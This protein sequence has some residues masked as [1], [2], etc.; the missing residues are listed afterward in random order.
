LRS[1][2]KTGEKSLQKT[3]RKETVKEYQLHDADTGSTE[4]QVA[5]LTERINRLTGHMVANRHDY[6]TQRGL[7][8]LVV[9]RRRLLSY[10]TREDV[11]RYHRLI[12]RLGLRK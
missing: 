5:L 1:L 11:G 10:L 2:R 12:K 7:M 3:K 6:S 9:Q 4:V 8:A